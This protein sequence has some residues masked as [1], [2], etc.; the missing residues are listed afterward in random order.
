MRRGI[1][2]LFIQLIASIAFFIATVIIAR[3]LGPEDFGDFSAAYS[4]ASVAYMIAL[5]GA[6][7][8]ATN[9]IA[10]SIKA[11]KEGQIKA[12]VIYVFII[13]ALLSIFYYIMAVCTYWISKNVFLLKY[14]HPVFIAVIFIPV[15]ALTFF[16][17][18]VLISFSK[19]ILANALFKILIN[20]S[21]LFLASLMFFVES[22]RRSHIAVVLFMLA[23]IVTFSVMLF[24]LAKRMKIFTPVR[25]K[26]E[27]R[28]WLNSGLSGLP[29]TLALFTLPY[30]AI[31]GAEV[32]LANEDSVGIFATAASFS[33]VIA[34]NFIACIQSVALAPIAIAIYNKK[35]LDVRVILNKHFIIIG[36][37]CITLVVIIFF[38]G[39]DL[40]LI[41]GE[42][43]TS[44]SNILTIFI[45]TQSI[46]LIGCLAAPI[47]IYL[48]KN[49]IVFLSS[50]LLIVF[51]VGF[52][53]VLGYVF[54][55][56]GLAIGVLL[57][58]LIVFL[59][60]NIYAYSLTSKN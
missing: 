50:I 59:F 31:I 35:L 21:M 27:Y 7:V 41:Y 33:Q 55:E 36:G 13:V 49:I 12:F 4:V 45:I 52:I 11:Q 8:I 46:I 47:L 19:P 16:F 23:W 53:S 30:L 32:F 26:I 18:R 44:G 28:S 48:K 17:Y 54:Q 1:I 29:Y 15:M 39:K 5:L 42:K 3:Y 24:I 37:L 9:V 56:Q 6:D 25:D 58:V 34:N 38:F 60:Q 10:V 14:T 51:L 57:A 40:L 2:L 22:F 43:Y 20:L